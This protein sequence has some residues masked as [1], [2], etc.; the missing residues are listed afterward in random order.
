M[1]QFCRLCADC[2]DEAFIS[3]AEGIDTD[4]CNHIE[5]TASIIAEKPYSFSMGDGKRKSGIIMEKKLLFGF[6]GYGQWFHAFF[7]LQTIEFPNNSVI[8]V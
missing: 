4:T 2:L 3:I 8:T 1:D 6:L 7:V 5:V